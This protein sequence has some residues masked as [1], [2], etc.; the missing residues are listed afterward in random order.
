M[1]IIAPP[2]AFQG[3]TFDLDAA[4]GTDTTVNAAAVTTWTPKLTSAN[5]GNFSQATTAQ[6]PT[7][8]ANGINSL[9]VVRFD[10]VNSNMSAAAGSTLGKLFSSRSWMLFVVAQWNTSISTNS[11]NSYQNAQI[12]GDGANN[13]F[14]V[15][16][17]SSV[18]PT[19]GGGATT[20]LG[21]YIWDGA[22]KHVYMGFSLN[23][24]FLYTMWRLNGTLYGQVGKSGVISSVACGSYTSGSHVLQ[25]GNGTGKAKV[26]IARAVGVVAPATPWGLVAW[27]RLLSGIYG[28]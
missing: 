19:A 4:S 26:D 25:L 14:G 2:P 18:A 27:Q 21:S 16:G 28:V 8:I 7:Y 20:C 22:D 1:L 13:F 12:I 6:K 23:T 10:G 17:R 9:P 24:P 15:F 3:Q 11:A 5:W